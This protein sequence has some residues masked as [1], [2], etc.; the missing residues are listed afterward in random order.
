MHISLL[1]FDFKL[2]N[3]SEKIP[4]F[5]SRYYPIINNF[6][7][8]FVLSFSHSLFKPGVRNKKQ[9]QAHP[10]PLKKDEKLYEPQNKFG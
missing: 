5:V 10:R 6:F 3:L 7:L 8:I 2:I 1:V 4:R 9:N